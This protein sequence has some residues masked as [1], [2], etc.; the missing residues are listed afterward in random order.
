MSYKAK[1]ADRLNDQNEKFRHDREV[2]LKREI[3]QATQEPSAAGK[4]KGPERKE[5]RKASLSSSG[6][7]GGGA[8]EGAAVP[9][10]CPTTPLESMVSVSAATIRE[11]VYVW[12]CLSGCP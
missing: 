8:E 4:K 6:A 7:A 10:I 2:Q 3:E 9:S 12:P 1:D 5:S 11:G